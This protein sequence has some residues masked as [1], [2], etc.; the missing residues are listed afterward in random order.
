MDGGFFIRRGVKEGMSIKNG[1]SSAYLAKTLD[2]A[3]PKVVF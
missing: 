3:A 2:R 1:L